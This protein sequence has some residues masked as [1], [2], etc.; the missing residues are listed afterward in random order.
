MVNNNKYRIS[1]KK[2][3]YILQ[4]TLRWAEYSDLNLL[5]AAVW[6]YALNYLKAGTQNSSHLLLNVCENY[7]LSACITKTTSYHLV[8]F[9]AEKAAPTD[10]H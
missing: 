4:Q 7:N 1:Y 3:I 9:T 6:G 5:W 10:F 8:L 2:N